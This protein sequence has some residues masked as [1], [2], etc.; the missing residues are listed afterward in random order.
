M[1]SPPAHR[2]TFFEGLEIAKKSGG[3]F[4]A[5]ELKTFMENHDQFVVDDTLIRE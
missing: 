2:I 5:E 4:N 1:F 3:S